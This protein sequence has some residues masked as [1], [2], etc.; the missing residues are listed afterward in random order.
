MTEWRTTVAVSV[1]LLTA[2]WW[3]AAWRAVPV[4]AADLEEAFHHTYALA[5]D[6]RVSLENVNGDVHV[7]SW[8]QNEV[9]VEA[10]KRASSQDRLEAIEIKID[11]DRDVLRIKTVYHR[12]FDNNPGGVEYALTV[13]RGARLDK[14]ELVNGGLEAEDLGG[15]VNASSVNGRIKVRGL[16]GGARLSVVNGHLEAAFDRLD[17]PKDVS[18]ESVNGA[19]DLALPADASVTLDA[20]TVSGSIDDDFGLPVTGQFVGHKLHGMLGDGRAQVRLSDVNGS[21]RIRRA[22]ETS[23]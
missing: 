23:N 14:F 19:I 1:F 11:S 16:S 8:T 12:H 2:G 18:L 17:E 13:P 10:I 21:I 4:L 9:R 6:G 22:R 5:A 3:L 7:T 15:A 20:S